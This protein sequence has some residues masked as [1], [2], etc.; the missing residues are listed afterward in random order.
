MGDSESVS[1]SN[2]EEWQWQWQWQWPPPQQQQQRRRHFETFRS[3]GS[4]HDWHD[5]VDAA[6][7]YCPAG[8][9]HGQNRVHEETGKEPH[10][11]SSP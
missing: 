10:V 2:R 11:P 3:V 9:A 4:T 8:H 7:R 5:A 1:E 6:L